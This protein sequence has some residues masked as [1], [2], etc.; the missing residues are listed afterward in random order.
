MSPEELASEL[1]VPLETLL[2]VI[3]VLEARS[4]INTDRS[5]PRSN[6]LDPAAAPGPLPATRVRLASV[7]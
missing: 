4:V 6:S 5:E 1:N 2:P 3:E 7:A